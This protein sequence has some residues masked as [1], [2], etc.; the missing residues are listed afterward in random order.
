MS[1]LV[2]ITHQAAVRNFSGFPGGGTVAH[3]CGFS[4]AHRAWSVFLS[5]LPVPELALTAALRS[6]LRKLAAEWGGVR[7]ALVALGLPMGPMRGSSTEVLP[8]ARQLTSTE[9]PECS[10]PELHPFNAPCCSYLPL[11]QSPFSPQSW[12]FHLSTLD[13]AGKKWVSLANYTT[14][15]KPC[16]RSL[17]SLSPV[18][19]VTTG[20]FSLCSLPWRTSKVPLSVSSASFCWWCCLL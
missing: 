17:L 14:A 5:A 1:F 9:D 12:N 15:G 10:H 11:S 2:L 8:E 7:L 20:G 6:A 3:V 13:A 18:T 16:T 19:E 4:L